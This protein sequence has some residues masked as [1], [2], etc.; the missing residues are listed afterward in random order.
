MIARKEK[1]LFVGPHCSVQSMSER[2]QHAS[3]HWMIELIIHKETSGTETRKCQN[4][5]KLVLVSI[6][7]DW[8]HVASD[9]HQVCQN[10]HDFCLIV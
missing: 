8:H 4:L 7:A 6:R 3:I 5:S 9:W 1:K 10:C 2:Q